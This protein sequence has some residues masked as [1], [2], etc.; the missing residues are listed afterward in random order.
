MIMILSLFRGVSATTL[1]HLDDFVFTINSK[2][3]YVGNIM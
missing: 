3:Y 2:W 1:N